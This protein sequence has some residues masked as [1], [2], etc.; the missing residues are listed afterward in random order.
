MKLTAM[1]WNG[2]DILH[3]FKEIWTVTLG[4]VLPSL[5]PTGNWRIFPAQISR[6][7]QINGKEVILEDWRIWPDFELVNESDLPGKG[8]SATD[9]MSWSLSDWIY[10]GSEPT[11]RV[12][13]VREAATDEV[14]GLDIPFLRTGVMDKI[15]LL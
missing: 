6:T 3:A 14:I 4:Q 15:R 13:L 2:T 8:I 11:D 5:R 1:N 9:C 12:V 7:S 10:Y